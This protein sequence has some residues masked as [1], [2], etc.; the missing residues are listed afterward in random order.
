MEQIQILKTRTYLEGLKNLLIKNNIDLFTCRICQDNSKKIHIHHIDGNVENNHLNNLAVLCSYCHFAIHFKPNSLLQRNLGNKWNKDREFTIE[1][2]KNLSKAFQ[3]KTYEEIYGEEVAKNKKEK[4]SKFMKEFMGRL[5]KGKT[6][7]ERYGKE[8]AKQI[9]EKI[10]LAKKGIKR[11]PFTEECKRNMS[12]AGKG[13][14][15]TEEHRK[16][17]GLANKKVWQKRKEL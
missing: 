5:S 12:I 10:G 9:K 4:H 8:R 17:I 15:F 16:K 2:K 1:H 11:K 3:N 7:E 6:Y 14:I 13:R